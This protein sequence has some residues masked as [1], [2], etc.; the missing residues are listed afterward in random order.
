MTFNP[1]TVYSEG[2][3]GFADHDLAF[4][5]RILW[6]YIWSLQREEPKSDLQ[7]WN[8]TKTVVVISPAVAERSVLE[9]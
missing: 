8:E 6:Y 4:L 9:M 5:L 3:S 7:V 1:P 2:S